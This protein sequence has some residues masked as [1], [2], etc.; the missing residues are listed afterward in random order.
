MITKI[1]RD[2]ALFLKE[3]KIYTNFLRYN[4]YKNIGMLSLRSFDWKNTSEGYAFWRG[5]AKEYDERLSKRLEE[6]WMDNYGR[7]KFY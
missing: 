3:N 1:S 2:F 4:R 7:N 6:Y 5:V